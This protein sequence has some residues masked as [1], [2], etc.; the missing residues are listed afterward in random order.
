LWGDGAWLTQ[1]ENSLT[2]SGIE[3]GTDFQNMLRFVK[4]G[5]I[6]GQTYGATTTVSVSDDGTT[7]VAKLDMTAMYAGTG[8]SWTRTLTYVRTTQTLTIN[9][10]YTVPAGVV[11]YFQLQLPV[12]PTLTASGFT[13]GHLQATVL[14]PGTPTITLDNWMTLSSDANSGWRVNISDPSGA[15]TGQFTVKLQ[16]V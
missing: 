9:D 2:K 3:Q 8:I 5:T 6:I 1:T 14:T 13:A 7:L 10:D 4:A 11:P 12:Q 16:V 15:T